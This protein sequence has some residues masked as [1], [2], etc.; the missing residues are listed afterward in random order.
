MRCCSHGNEISGRYV[1]L[2]GVM[3]H[4][5]GSGCY[6]ILGAERFKREGTTTTL[7]CRVENRD[8]QYIISKSS[9]IQI[10][11]PVYG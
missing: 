9:K 6:V 4:K 11:K 10:Y 3:E 7:Y 5:E 1:I 8:G 2:C